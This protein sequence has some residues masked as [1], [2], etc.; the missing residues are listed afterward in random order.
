M[1]YAVLVANVFSRLGGLLKGA[2]RGLLAGSSTSPT[3]AF[4][5]DL[6]PEE[7][8][9][10][11]RQR[12]VAL[13]AAQTVGGPAAWSRSAADLEVLQRMV[14]E[15]VFSPTQT[16]ELQALGVVFGDVLE[17]ELG[18]RWVVVMDELGTD[19]TLRFR[20]TSIQVNALTMIAQRVTEGRPVKLRELMEEVRRSLPT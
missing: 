12:R 8:Q 10:M 16:F 6:T 9:R 18:L 19:P 7:H 3:G 1:C 4:F 17:T 13:A 14:D 5:A 2:A 15:E 11:E 20:D